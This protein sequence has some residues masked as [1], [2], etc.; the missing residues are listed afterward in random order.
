MVCADATATGLLGGR[1]SA[2]V[3][4]TMLHHVPSTALQDR[5]F[6]EIHR[7]IRPGGVLAGQDSLGPTSCANCTWTTP[8]CPSIRPVWPGGW[9]APGS[10]ASG[11]TPTSTPSGSGP[12]G[13]PTDGDGAGIAGSLLLAGPLPGF[14]RF[15]VAAHRHREHDDG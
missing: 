9:R 4:L 3:C 11:S 14:R 7:L 8:T 6:A 13:R 10:S 1:F 5:L 12:V 15:D 2:A